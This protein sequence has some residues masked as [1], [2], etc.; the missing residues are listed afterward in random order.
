MKYLDKL[1]VLL[2]LDGTLIDTSPLYFKGIPPIIKKYLDINITEKDLLPLWGQ[3]A[4]NFFSHFY[5][6]LRNKE[7]ASIVDTMYNEFSMFYNQ[8]HNT[9]AQPYPF[10]ETYLPQLKQAAQAVGVVTTRPSHRSKP[11]LEMNWASWV[12]FFIWGDQVAR[13]KPF[14][15]GLN[16]AIDGYMEN[17]HQSN[18]HPVYVGDNKHDIEAAKASKYYM[19]SVAALWGTM[20]TSRLLSA[21]PDYAFNTFKDFATWILSRPNELK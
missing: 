1:L 14:P 9:L 2:D 18:C 15:D 16:L 8:M 12:D 4:R 7:D 20:N 11:V 13:Y 3:Y 10:V 19:I 5:E 21:N 17:R 6:T